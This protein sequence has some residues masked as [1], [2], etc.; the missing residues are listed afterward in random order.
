MLSS[1]FGRSPG[2]AS[3]A[4]TYASV[5]TLERCQRMGRSHPCGDTIA[6]LLA[7]ENLLCKCTSSTT[8]FRGSNNAPAGRPGTLPG[9]HCTAG[10][11]TA[12]R[13]DGT[14]RAGLSAAPTPR[15]GFPP[16]V[17]TASAFVAP[18]KCRAKS[19]RRRMDQTT[20]QV[21]VSGVYQMEQ[22]P[23]SADQ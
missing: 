2:T 15:S 6:S 5:H 8:M 12:R 20:L 4:G 22:C 10:S 23:S 9:S 11:R 7:I 17:S 3:R 19:S 1:T 16:P 21:H 13:P 14:A 18:R